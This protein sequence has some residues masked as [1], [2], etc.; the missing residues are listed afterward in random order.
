M[1]RL[2]TTAQTATD[3][4]ARLRASLTP[5]EID[6]APADRFSGEEGQTL[7]EYALI[8]SLVAIVVIAAVTLFGGELTAMFDDIT[9]SFEGL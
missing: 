6:P 5:G 9:S 8:L 2:R 1:D 4:I 7:A 3:V